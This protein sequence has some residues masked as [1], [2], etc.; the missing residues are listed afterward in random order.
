M[1]V[2]NFSK[3]HLGIEVI[4]KPARDLIVSLGGFHRVW[5]LFTDVQDEISW[6]NKVISIGC[7]AH[8]MYGCRIIVWMFEGTVSCDYIYAVLWCTRICS[9][10]IDYSDL[11]HC[12]NSFNVKGKWRKVKL[13]SPVQTWQLV[14]RGSL[15]TPQ[16]EMLVL[17]CCNWIVARSQQ[18]I[19]IFLI[20]SI[21]I[22]KCRRYF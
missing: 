16:G 17:G 19:Y 3:K 12:W 22:Y 8:L 20:V 10:V 2:D 11:W 18:N 9:V 15:P 5:Q 13:L 14:N 7:L 1:N 4:N 6:T 21:N